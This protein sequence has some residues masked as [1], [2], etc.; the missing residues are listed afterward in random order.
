MANYPSGGNPDPEALNKVLE[1]LAGYAIALRRIKFR[2]TE[3]GTGGFGTV[4]LAYLRSGSF[5]Q[6][7]ERPT[8]VAVK[9]LHAVAGAELPM[10]LAFRLAREMKV[11]ASC[12]H[13]NVLEFTGF[14]LA[15]DYRKAYLISPYMKNGNVRDYLR[16]E[17]P[18][19]EARLELI[20]DAT[21]GLDYLHKQDPPV[22][23]GDLKTLNV[24]VNDDGRALLSDFGLAS[25][26]QDTPTGLS[27]SK[28]FKGTFRFSSPEALDF[29]QVECPADIWSWGILAQEIMTDKEPY[30]QWKN[31]AVVIGMICGPDDRRSP[32]HPDTSAV[33]PRLLELIRRCW[34]L[35]VGERPTSTICL[36]EMHS[37]Y[38]AVTEGSKAQPISE[39]TGTLSAIAA[40]ENSALR[41][42]ASAASSART[43]STR[44][45]SL[46]GQ[47]ARI[48]GAKTLVGRYLRPAKP[49][50]T[51]N[52]GSSK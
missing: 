37:I 44:R 5:T 3:L 51:Q 50:H 24:L 46:P 9:E 23:H 14:Y 8:T 52:P 29:S 17:T 21:K 31:E 33:P 4:R 19:P 49:R 47:I 48:A 18:S 43:P 27:T 11:W 25:A 22:V 34:S 10:R 6:F 39:T 40:P 35:E 16:R 26:K 38:F 36:S 42:P 32:E 12:H 41:S 2:G 1:E 28:G 30:Y 15:D 7:F 20:I 45:S 13:P